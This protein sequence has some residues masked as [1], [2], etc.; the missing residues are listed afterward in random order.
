MQHVRTN[1]ARIFLCMVLSLLMAVGVIGL[2]SDRAGFAPLADAMTSQTQGNYYIKVEVHDE[3]TTWSKYDSCNN[4]AG[5]MVVPTIKQ[6]GSEGPLW[7]ATVKAGE[8]DS[9]NMTATYYYHANGKNA[10]ASTNVAIAGFPVG[11]RKVQTASATATNWIKNNNGTWTSRER[12]RVYVSS[13][14]STWTCVLDYYEDTSAGG[15]WSYTNAVDSSNYP[16][17]NSVGIS[18]SG[19][20][21][22]NGTATA[23]Y[24]VTSAKDQY[25]V[26]WGFSSV[27]WSSGHS[28]VK[29]DADGTATFG[30]NGFSNY[31]AAITPTLTNG[32]GNSSKDTKSVSVTVAATALSLDTDYNINVPSG[33][34]AWYSYTPSSDGTFIFFSH[35]D[36]GDPLYNCYEG[37]ATSGFANND[38]GPSDYRAILGL[39]YRQFYQQLSLTGG[40]T[41]YF[42]VGFW[43]TGSGNIVFRLASSVTVTFNATGGT[44][45]SYV[46]PKGYDTMKLDQTGV[47]R[48]GHTLVGWSTSNTSSQAKYKLKSETIAVPTSDKTYYALWSPDNAPELTVNTDYATTIDAAG[49]VQ[50]YQFTPTETGKYLI[51]GTCD[52]D[53]Y[54]LRYDHDT[55]RNNGQYID[56]QDDSSSSSNG[57]TTGYDFGIGGPQ[58]FMLRTLE[59]GTTYEFGVKFYYAV[60]GDLTFRFEKVYT[61]DYDAN[62]G[63]GAPTV[64]HD[65]FFDKGLTL[66]SDEPTAPEHYV[67]LGWSTNPNATAAEYQPGDTYTANADATL[68]AVWELE[69]HTVIFKSWDGT[70]LKTETVD[71]GSDANPPEIPDRAPTDDFHYIKGTWTGYTNITQDTTLTAPYTA[72]PHAGDWGNNTATCTEGG[73]ETRTCTVCGKVSTRSTEALGHDYEDHD[74]KTPT[75]MEGGWAP[76]QTCSRCDYTSYQA[77]GADPENHTG[78]NT[79]TREDVV[80]ATCMAKGSYTE[81]VTC[82]CGVELSRTP[83]KEI[84]VNPE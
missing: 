8:W 28:A 26:N 80:D 44:D 78:N 51:Y 9:D 62:G 67:F 55:W 27:S 41:Y 69:K 68:Y 31:T 59:A 12:F 40:T 65:K 74:G 63:T 73:T 21:T 81:V 24:T 6:D 77:L 75:C 4:S 32:A 54:V 58:F 71:Y 20:V 60:T 19:S 5:Y 45:K 48:S 37:N 61:V 13:D 15:N 46:L 23:T 36:S 17:L 42:K 10:A 82:E 38:D 53:S 14:N 57:N 52:T 33:G 34:E 70:V 49:E 47:S 79:T 1:R 64:V 39:Q 7:Y 66:S 30:A 2:L 3:T 76:Y 29:I 18:G 56:V 35:T 84:P 16:H 25:D 11:L 72:A 83:D 43:S 22:T 50:F